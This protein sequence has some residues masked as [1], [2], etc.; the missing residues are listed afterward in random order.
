MIPN[1]VTPFYACQAPE[2]SKGLLAFLFFIYFVK[3]TFE[4]FFLDSGMRKPRATMACMCSPKVPACHQCMSWHLS[5]K[6]W[7]QD[8]RD[9]LTRSMQEDSEDEDRHSNS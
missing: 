7:R 3:L 9:A 5:S 4:T 1:K 6:K 2:C 8:V